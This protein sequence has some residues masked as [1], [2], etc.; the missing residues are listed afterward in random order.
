MRLACDRSRHHRCSRN[1]LSHTPIV[2]LQKVDL[3]GKIY[4]DKT[5]NF[6]ITSSK[7]NTYILVAYHYDSNTTHEEPLKREL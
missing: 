6:T 2:F 4:T 3:I 1:Y 7:D 5:G